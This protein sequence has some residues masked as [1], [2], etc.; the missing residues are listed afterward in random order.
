MIQKQTVVN[1]II[2]TLG[3]LMIKKHVFWYISDYDVVRGL[4]EEL[5]I[6]KA[7]LTEERD[8]LSAS[9]N[10]TTKELHRLQKQSESLSVPAC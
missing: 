2:D 1:I 9:L 6:T 4:T 3:I 7:N 5:S 8:L 10:E